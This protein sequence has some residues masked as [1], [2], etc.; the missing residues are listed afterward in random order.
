MSEEGE[1]EAPGNVCD[2]LVEVLKGLAWK[3]QPIVSNWELSGRSE[4]WG[5]GC[6]SRL[7]G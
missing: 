7:K 6:C 2:D 1:W 5:V 4:G 3:P